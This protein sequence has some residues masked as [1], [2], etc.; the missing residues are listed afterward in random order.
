MN[1]GKTDSALHFTA[2]A[3]GSGELF[4]Y[5]GGQWGILQ[6]CVIYSSEA[7]TRLETGGVMR[8]VFFPF[9]IEDVSGWMTQ[10]A[11]KLKAL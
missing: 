2:E 6:S 3:P 10:L 8:N 1:I 9:L 4:Q 7:G 11:P 5:R